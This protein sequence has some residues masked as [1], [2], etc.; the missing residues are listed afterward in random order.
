M[1]DASYGG[2]LNGDFRIGIVFVGQDDKTNVLMA[3]EGVPA[4]AVARQSLRS[5]VANGTSL[6]CCDHDHNTINKIT[7]SV[8]L[9]PDPPRCL[10]DSLFVG[11]EGNALLCVSLHSTTICPSDVFA[12]YYSLLQYLKEK[13]NTFL[14]VEGKPPISSELSMK[15]FSSGE[16][17]PLVAIF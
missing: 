15:H 12:Y 6:Q 17:M 3:R 2:L 8:N 4:K 13:A 9:Y 11:D 1:E 10:S 7:P 5:I 14:E 16:A